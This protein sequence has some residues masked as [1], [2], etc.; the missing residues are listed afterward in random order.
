MPG[1][2]KLFWIDVLVLSFIMSEYYCF[3]GR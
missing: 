2:E 1:T 3:D